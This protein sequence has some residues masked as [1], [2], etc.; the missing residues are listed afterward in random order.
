M[1]TEINFTGTVK[2][3]A[4]LITTP[5]DAENVGESMGDCGGYNGSYGR[6][7]TKLSPHRS[8]ISFCH[9]KTTNRSSD[10]SHGPKNKV[11]SG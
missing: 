1:V 2:Y 10:T 3:P 8:V 9:Q 7:A 5:K 4:L 6:R 11:N